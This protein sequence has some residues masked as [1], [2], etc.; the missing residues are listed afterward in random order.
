MI[1]LGVL[2]VAAALGAAY[3]LLMSP[4][5]PTSR[6]YPYHGPDAERVVALTFDDGPN[7]P[8]T[9]QILDLLAAHDI[10]ATFFHVGHCVERHP[11]VARRVIEDGH[12]V[13]NHSLSHT[14]GTYLR[15]GAFARE[16]EQTQ[17]ILSRVIGRTPALARTP[18]LWRQPALLRMLRRR[19]LH[20]VAGE[21]CHALEVFQISG[22]RMAR[23]AIAKTRP[24]SIL[25]FHDGFDGHGGDRA[26]TVLAV[27]DTI[28]GLTARGYRFVTV[29]E[30]LGVP[31]YR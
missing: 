5:S 27:R 6:D 16:V 25:I 3:W 12:I 9:S 23:R 7:E 29:D 26:Q 17:T 4:F 14:F 2:A 1:V 31:A 13:G 21:F 10:R 20:P 11:E 24:G 18:W 15:P 30:L 28:E 19:D 22:A 8:Y